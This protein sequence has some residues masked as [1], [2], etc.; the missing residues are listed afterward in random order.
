MQVVRS[1][2]GHQHDDRSLEY[3]LQRDALGFDTLAVDFC[4]I[5]KG[6]GQVI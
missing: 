5:K 3:A 2:H 1:F 4:G 6:L